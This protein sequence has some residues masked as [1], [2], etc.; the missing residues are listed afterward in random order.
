[1]ILGLVCLGACVLLAVASRAVSLSVPLNPASS[2]LLVEF[3]A[4]WPAL[5]VY[6]VRGDFPVTTAL[7][8]SSLAVLTFI[9]GYLAFGGSTEP[10]NLSAKS[11]RPLPGL[12]KIVLA[13]IVVLIL[14][15]FFENRGIPPYGSALKAIINPSDGT[16][17]GTIRD[18]RKLLTKAH[19]VGAE[20]RGQGI[21]RVI[22]EVGWQ[23]I[24]ATM[25]ASSTLGKPLYRRRGQAMVL[26]VALISLSANGVRSTVLSIAIVAVLSYALTKGVSKRLFLYSVAIFFGLFM[27]ISPLSKGSKQGGESL[28]ERAASVVERVSTGNG[29]HNAE[30]ILLIDNGRL[31]RQNG[32][33]NWEK[34]LA[35]LPGI[36]GASA[37]PFALRLTRLIYHVNEFNTS[38]STS[39][40]LGIL[41]ADGG[42][43]GIAVGYFIAGVVLAKTWNYVRNRAQDQS[44]QRLAVTAGLAAIVLYQTTQYAI[45]GIH[46]F[47]V[48]IVMALAM[49][50]M[51]NFSSKLMSQRAK[52][53]RSWM[54]SA[55]T[56]TKPARYGASV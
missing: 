49:E 44:G 14:I 54:P 38:Y 37:E 19:L 17:S 26:L 4:V 9:A 30:I 5:L 1:M 33:I 20:Y 11:D 16:A 27:L 24:I 35:V 43:L 36:Q 42:F 55:V 10:L 28:S 48:P 52:S 8:A 13:S 51:W 32:A 45:G 23:L 25:I 34:T 56:S 31:E 12:G 2:L 39:T 40:Q 7:L 29:R 46:A 21:F 3:I 50:G 15:Q 53:Q 18:N 47:V 41:Y 6:S 22:S